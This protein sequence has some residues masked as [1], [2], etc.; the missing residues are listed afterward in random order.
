M[1][2]N[3]S[4]S[5]DCEVEMISRDQPQFKIVF[6]G[7]DNGGK[8]SILLVLEHKFSLLTN[9]A[10]TK[11]VDRTEFDVLGYPIIRWDLGGQ[12]QFRA[13]HI[14]NDQLDST[15]LL[16]Y[17]IDIQDPNRFDEAYEYLSE[18]IEYFQNTEQKIPHL[19]ICLHK[20]D[21]DL[22]NNPDIQA[23]IKLVEDEL[24]ERFDFKYLI[25]HTSIYNNWTLRQA[26]S[27]GLLKLSSKSALLDSM[28]EDFL[29]ITHSDT[30]LLLDKDALIFSECYQDE[31]CYELSN[32]LAPHLATMAD[33]LV[34]YGKEIE[35]FEGRIGGWIY[36]KPINVGNK[37]FYI[38]VFNQKI[39]S[40]EEINY[41]LPDLTKKIAN[42]LQTFFI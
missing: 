41:A 37:T 15:D 12:S 5:N 29:E 6:C 27:K 18:V 28:L 14:K 40:F 42:S 8:T 16:F 3:H 20:Y 33:R 11:G 36:F 10:P 34:K 39:D 17:V 30:L 1:L 38:V 24:K 23:N 7:L 2:S 35:I 32:L 19:V 26:F 25:F 31:R 9:I 22:V 13:E 21:P 4:S